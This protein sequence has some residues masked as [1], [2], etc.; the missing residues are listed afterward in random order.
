M[1]VSRGP[2]RGPNTKLHMGYEMSRRGHTAP[3]GEIYYTIAESRATTT[4]AHEADSGQEESGNA[5]G[6]DVEVRLTG[7]IDQSKT[8]NRY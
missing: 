2:V 4:S 7:V 8:L 1:S 5:R 3:T 6:G